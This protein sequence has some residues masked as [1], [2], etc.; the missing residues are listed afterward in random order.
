MLCQLSNDLRPWSEGGQVYWDLEWNVQSDIIWM[1]CLSWPHIMW[2]TCIINA[3]LVTISVIKYNWLYYLY[4][5]AGQ[6]TRNVA[7]YIVSTVLIMQ[8][9]MRYRNFY[10]SCIILEFLW[11]QYNKITRTAS[12]IHCT[13]I[14]SSSMHMKWG[15]VSIY[16]LGTLFLRYI[17]CENQPCTDCKVMHWNAIACPF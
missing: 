13:Y 14:Y 10:I 9:K 3:G 8:Y 17:T 12:S 16:I 15:P 6:T 7:D 4:W 11:F 5:N 1:I 2:K